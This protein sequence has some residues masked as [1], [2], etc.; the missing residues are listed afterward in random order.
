L[1]K[2][3]CERSY[4]QLLA[5]NIWSPWPHLTPRQSLL[6]SN[7]SLYRTIDQLSFFHTD[8]RYHSQL[9]KFVTSKI[10]SDRWH[11]R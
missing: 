1:S 10:W 8:P 11:H 4:I 5:M 7:W 6:T 2:F 3:W 9:K